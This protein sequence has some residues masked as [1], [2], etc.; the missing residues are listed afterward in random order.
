MKTIYINESVIN[1]S[2]FK[3]GVLLN[4]L[5]SDIIDK[6]TNNRTSL[7]NN[8]S[9]PDIFDSPF[10]LNV[11]EKR[12]NETK[13]RL[14][15]I[16]RIDDVEETD[17]YSAL[18]ALIKKCKEI[19]T[20]YR[21]ELERLCVNYVIDLFCVPSETV[22][23]VVEL[24]DNIDTGKSS[25]ILD[26][27]G[28]DDELE[29]N[30]L[31][32]MFLLKGEIYKRRIL[33]SLCMGGSMRLSNCINDFS[34]TLHKINPNLIK[35]YTQILALNEYLLFEKED[36]GMSD[37]N[38]MQLG[39]VEVNLAAGDEKVKIEAQGVIMP[40]LL[41]ELIRGFME[42]FISHGL[43]KK[44]EIAMMVLGKSDFL[45]AEPWDM[46]VGPY[47]WDLLSKSFN[48][49]NSNELPYLLKRI[50]KLEV[51]NFNTLLKEVF[52]KTKRGK[53]I[54]SKLSFKAKKDVKYDKFVDKMS[55]MKKDKGVIT[56]EFIHPD[57]L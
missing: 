20:P 8:P 15:N 41:N 46:R 13:Q 35:Y 25:I 56:D 7:G 12:F 24:T 16:G 28:G 23:I 36:I 17:M 33:D 47:L 55:K 4:E 40:I 44:K 29:L 49:I 31:E 5:P 1:N 11:T 34:D 27:L 54:M 19:E 48:D 38:K 21:S 53:E 57:E 42:L 30:T 43:P 14:K 6:I 50:S 37:E 51:D 3:K 26:P 18:S 39:T 32:D 52:A 9:L 10:L 45:K 2:E 22:D